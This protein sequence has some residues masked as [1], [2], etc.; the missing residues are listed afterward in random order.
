MQGINREA[1]KTTA[2]SLP[3]VGLPSVPGAVA[4]A[5]FVSGRGGT[6]Q[7]DRQPRLLCSPS[8]ADPSCTRPGPE[9]AIIFFS[10]AIH[11]LTLNLL[12]KHEGFQGVQATEQQ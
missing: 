1:I 9:G 12:S 2:L 3:N 7:C 8:I 6:G 10:P 11:P 5:A 4:V